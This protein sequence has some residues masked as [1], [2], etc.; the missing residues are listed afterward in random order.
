MLT[1]YNRTNVKDYG[2]FVKHIVY[3]VELIAFIKFGMVQNGLYLRVKEA[4]IGKK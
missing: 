4:V 2:R 1:K 3:Y